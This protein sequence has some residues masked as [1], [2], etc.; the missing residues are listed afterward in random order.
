VAES[1]AISPDGHLVAAT[2]RDHPEVL[3]W[4][5]A[6][7]Q[8]IAKFSAPNQHDEAHSVAFTPDGKTLAVAFQSDTSNPSVLL[9]DVPSSDGR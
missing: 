6:N 8:Q 4:D 9:F 3:L 1:A 5:V 7:G 2:L